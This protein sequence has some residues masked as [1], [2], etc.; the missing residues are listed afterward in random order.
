MELGQSIG[1]QNESNIDQCIVPTYFMHA[2]FLHAYITTGV[3][4]HKLKAAPQF[5]FPEEAVVY[6]Q[7]T[8]IYSQ[9]CT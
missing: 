3:V 8:F 9:F 1:P 2:F 4:I 6:G 5:C 7:L